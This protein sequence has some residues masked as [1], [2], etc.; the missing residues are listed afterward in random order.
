MTRRRFT[1]AAGPTQ[2]IAVRLWINGPPT[3]A[4]GETAQF[5]ATALLSEFSKP[6]YDDIV[7][8]FTATQNDVLEFSE[9]HLCA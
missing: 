5:S 4:L 9:A 2:T 3:I 6:G 1:A 8:S 7:K